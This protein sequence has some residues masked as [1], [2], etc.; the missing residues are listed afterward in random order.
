MPEAASYLARAE[1]VRVIPVAPGTG[2]TTT[3]PRTLASALAVTTAVGAGW[4]VGC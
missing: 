3:L 2:R 1:I 4:A